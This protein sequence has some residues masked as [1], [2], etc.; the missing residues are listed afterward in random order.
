MI[1]PFHD[2]NPTK[3]TPLFTFAI[4]AV[5]AV[6]FLGS[7]QL[8][9]EDR[10]VLWYAR[11]FVPARIAQLAEPRPL[12]V[13]VPVEAAPPLV[14]RGMVAVRRLQLPPVR[15][16]ILLSLLTSMFLH[17]GWL[18]L[19]GNMWFLWVFGN[20]VEDRLGHVAFLAFYLLGGL[21]A[22]A[23][24]WM[25][26]PMSTTPVIGASGA[27]ATMLGA[28]AITWPWARVKSLVFLFIIITVIDLPALLVL[29]VW[30]LVQLISATNAD[31]HMGGGVAWWAHVGG[32][33]TGMLLMPFL[34]AVL[35]AG[36][37]DAR[38]DEST[39][40]A[41]AATTSS[42]G[43]TTTSDEPLDDRPSTMGRR[44]LRKIDPGLDLSRHLKTFD[45]LPRPW[46]AAAL[47]GRRA[48]L[49]VEVG[50]GKGLFLRTA[51]AGRPETDFLGIEIAAKYARFSAAGLAKRAIPN[52]VV[53][54]ADALAVFDELLPDACLAAVHV[55]FPDPW[56]KKRHKKRRMMREAFVRHVERTLLPGGRLHFWT[57]VEEYFH[58]T[59]D[60]VAAHTNLDGPYDVPV[61]PASNDLDYRTHFERRVRLHGEPVYRSEYVKP[62]P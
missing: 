24:H 55:Y 59:L 5:N 12:I 31:V 34:S 43:P 45:E 62:T 9:A 28:Y 11:G 29:S 13:D 35:N 6:V 15:G 10:T 18:H 40:S 41:S 30:F 50:S 27:V 46:D 25:T 49:E 36:D 20:N 39:C 17:G 33:L 32:F 53:A 37:Q 54:I 58:T 48:P 19:I 1:F 44:A 26:G 7:L 14:P 16:Q 2:E 56:W 60:L 3:R 52:A 42:H 51:A 61:A 21:V 22:T 38:S 57:D 4:I 47:F 8:S 23:C